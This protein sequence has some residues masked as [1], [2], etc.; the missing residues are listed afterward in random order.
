MERK[1]RSQFD[2]S[3]AAALA[4]S[5]FHTGDSRAR[6]SGAKKQKLA[7]EVE[8]EASRPQ[9]T[10]CNTKGASQDV[11]RMKRKDSDSK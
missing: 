4:V 2:P 11:S 6:H 1:S 5:L 10:P 8:S 9:S 3:A 7:E